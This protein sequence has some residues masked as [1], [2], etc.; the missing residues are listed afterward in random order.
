MSIYEQVVSNITNY[1]KNDS[2]IISVYLLGSYAKGTFTSK[3]DIDIGII[4][5]NEHLI[6]SLDISSI[7]TDLTYEIGIT[8]D[9]GVISSKNLVYASEVIYTG[10]LL[11]CSN[12]DLDNLK[13][14][15]LLGMYHRFNDDRKEILNAYRT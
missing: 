12:K 15:N 11:Y 13:K 14:A 8:V 4:F 1:V 2:R 10:K 5:H 3:S 6:T 9:V 7:A